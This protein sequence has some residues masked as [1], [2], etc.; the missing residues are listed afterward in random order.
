MIIENEERIGRF[1]SSQMYRLMPQGKVKMTPEELAEFK[2]ANPKSKATT[3]IGGFSQLGETYIRDKQIERR[4]GATIDEGGYSRYGAWGNFMELVVFSH[5]KLR[6]DISS[7]KTTSH[8]TLGEYWSGSCDLRI[9]DTKGD[10][11][12][13][14]EI[15]CYWRKNFAL[16]ADCLM[17]KDINLFRE[18]FPK[19]Y[20]QIISN[21]I[22]H[23]VDVGEAIVY[24]PYISEMEEIKELAND[25]EGENKWHYRFIA[26]E[27]NY[28]LPCLPDGGY[29]ENIYTFEFKIPKSDK[30][31]MIS[32]IKEAIKLLKN[33]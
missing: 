2:L 26:E 21:A 29:Y 8:P 9:I 31:Y 33:E 27:P 18:E 7:Q 20:W 22:I 32:R 24:M 11:V 5:L 19:E 3:R 16:Y 28:K 17:K 1:T 23:N 15:K 14:S 12:G 30:D 13:I 4:M 6:Y 10:I 25:Y